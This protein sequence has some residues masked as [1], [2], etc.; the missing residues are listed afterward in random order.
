MSSRIDP[1]VHG[2]GTVRA[3]LQ[4]ALL[5]AASALLALLLELVHLPAALLIGP[6]IAGIAVGVNG[7]TI[8]VP[9]LAFGAAQAVIGCM[10]AAA[11]SLS[12][13]ISIGEN[14]AVT[15]AVVFA[16]IAASTL[17]GWLISRWKIMPGTTAVWGSAPGAASVMVLMAG[18]FGADQRLVAFMQYLRVLMVTISAAVVARLWIDPATLR[19]VEIDWFPPPGSGLATTITVVIAGMILGPLVRIPSPHLLGVM[20]LAGTVH[21][22]FGLPLDLPPWLLA[23]SYAVVGWAIGLNFTLEILRY[24]A[25]ATPRIALSI[26]ALMGFCAL[27]AWLLVH[28]MG[29]DPLTAYLATSPGGMDSVAIIAAASRS[30]DLS[31]VMAIQ[32]ARFLVVLLIGPS[33]ARVVVKSLG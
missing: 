16:T 4:W 27:L 9:Q 2:L 20:L 6:L 8:R 7:G 5:I 25:R 17:S 14:W 21:V 32:A 33:L 22:W 29:V 30:V 15:L 11:L 26:L 1:P 24:A 10:V 12:T 19:A 23:I 28:T 31:F 3:E 18:A 13:F